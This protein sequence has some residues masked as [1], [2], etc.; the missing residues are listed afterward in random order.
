MLV[1]GDHKGNL[2]TAVRLFL[3]TKRVENYFSILGAKLDLG[4]KVG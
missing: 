3:A 2:E 1:F 4:G